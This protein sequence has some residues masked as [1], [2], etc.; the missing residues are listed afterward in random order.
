MDKKNYLATL[1]L[2]MLTLF[3]TACNKPA[4]EDD[5][6]DTSV[7]KKEKAEMQTGFS[8][9]S[10][11][12][13][14]VDEIVN[15]F[16][17][18]KVTQK[19]YTKAIDLFEEVNDEITENLDKF[20][21]SSSSEQEFYIKMNLYQLN[22][23]GFQ[24]LQAIVAQANPEDLGQENNKRLEELNKK[25]NDKQANLQK[26]MMEKFQKTAA[27]APVAAPAANDSIK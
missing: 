17:A 21:D 2:V 19:D 18:G 6:D 7:T 27:A 8:G 16:L 12:N 11:G 13:A 3:A 1:L 24:E 4:E 26:K 10:T 5:D 20:I 15:K 9:K 25:F 22:L 23:N 14:D